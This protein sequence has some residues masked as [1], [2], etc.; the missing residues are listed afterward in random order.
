MTY[1]Q[2]IFVAYLGVLALLSLIAFSAFLSDKKKAVK[3][4]ERTKEKVLLGLAAFGGAIGAF[5]GRIVAHH[6]TDKSYFSIVIYFS[7]LLQVGVAV[8]L[9]VFAFI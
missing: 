2:I 5:F 8:L 4:A 6:K 9:G 1:Q 3:G 7:L